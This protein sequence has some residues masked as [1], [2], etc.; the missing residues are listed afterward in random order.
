MNSLQQHVTRCYL[1][2]E[3]VFQN[4]PNLRPGWISK[5]TPT[6][7]PQASKSPKRK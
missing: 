5:S 6:L 4:C 2:S 1:Q 3:G 7:G